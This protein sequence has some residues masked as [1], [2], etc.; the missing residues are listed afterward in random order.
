MNYDNDWLIWSVEHSAFWAPNAMGYT[1][2]PFA[3][4]HYS[5]LEAKEICERANRYSTTV[6]EQMVRLVEANEK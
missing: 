5:Y 2:D 4:G 1:R 6:R 3:A